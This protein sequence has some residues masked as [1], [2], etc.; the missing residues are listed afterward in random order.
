MAGAVRNSMSFMA[1][2]DKA[3]ERQEDRFRVRVKAVMEYSMNALL[4]RTPVNTGRAVR[5][6]VF[7]VGKGAN[8]GVKPGR[9]PVEAT[10]KLAL[11]QEALRPEAEAAARATLEGYDFANPYQTFS[12]VNNAPHIAGLEYGLLPYAPL[13]QRSKQGMFRVTLQEVATMLQAGKF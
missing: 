13:V 8:F 1:G 2:L 9:K 3:V 12:I 11:G 7:T 5:N 4:A 6:Y 10:N